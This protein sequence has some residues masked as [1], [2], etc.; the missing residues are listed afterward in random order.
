MVLDNVSNNIWIIILICICVLCYVNIDWICEIFKQGILVI[1]NK[2]NKKED[3]VV[4]TIDKN[5]GGD[6]KINNEHMTKSIL[7]KYNIGNFSTVDC[8]D[9]PI[10]FNVTGGGVGSK[11][12]KTTRI[13]DLDK[14]PRSK[15]EAEAIRLLENCVNAKFPTV[16]PK[17][18]MW[19]GHTL[20]LDGY[21]EKLKLAMEFSGP[22]HTKWN[23][24]Y[25]SYLI[26]FSRIVRDVVKQRMCKKHGVKLIILDVSLNKLH[27]NNYILSRLFDYGMKEKPVVYIEE[28]QF[29]PYRN[30]Q[31]EAELGLNAEMDAARLT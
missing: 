31:I 8:D 1:Y 15:S 28:Q 4:N 14:H 12:Q 13:K 30:P 18:L 2:V 16:Y 27:W 26:Y 20:E 10:I 7:K 19:R 17:W 11:K 6:I 29:I 24:S 21:N 22:L 9:I 25:E 5:G 3:I 23:P